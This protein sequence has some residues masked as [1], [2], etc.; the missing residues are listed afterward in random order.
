MSGVSTA[1][2]FL[3]LYREGQV[4]AEDIDDFIDSWHDGEEAEQSMPLHE[5]LGMLQA[6]YALWVQDPDILPHLL[7]ISQPGSK[8]T[9]N[10]A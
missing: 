9:A 7:H 4:G 5:F 8:T 10:S 2:P 3:Q 6:D 1:K